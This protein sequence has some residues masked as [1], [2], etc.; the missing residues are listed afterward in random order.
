MKSEVMIFLLCCGQAVRLFI[1]IEGTVSGFLHFREPVLPVPGIEELS[2]APGNEK[3]DRIL[4]GFSVPEEI[5]ILHG[6]HNVFFIPQRVAFLLFERRNN[7][8]ADISRIEGISCRI[9]TEEIHRRLRF[10]QNRCGRCGGTGQQIGRKA[11]RDGE[12]EK[13]GRYGGNDGK[14]LS[15]IFLPP[16][17]KRPDG[18]ENDRIEEPPVAVFQEEGTCCQGSG[19]E[20]KGDSQCN[21]RAF[22]PFPDFRDSQS[23]K[24]NRRNDSD[25]SIGHIFCGHQG[26]EQDRTPEP[27]HEETV[28]IRF[29]FPAGYHFADRGTRPGEKRCRHQEKVVVEMIVFGMLGGGRPEDIVKA[30]ELTDEVFSVNQVHAD[31][32]G[33]TEKKENQDAL[34]G[35]KPQDQSGLFHGKTPENKQDARQDKSHRSLGEAG[36][37]GSAVGNHQVLFAVFR[38]PDVGGEKS[39]DGEEK[40]HAVCD[41]CMGNDPEFQR[42]REDDAGPG[43]NNIVLRKAEQIVSQQGCRKSPADGSGQPGGQVGEA[44]EAVGD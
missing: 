43:G 21:R 10:R 35:E 42:Q 27:D 38:D 1:L 4:C 5:R 22:F 23:G 13:C 33:Q 25:V 15:R 30:Q 2:V 7:P 18:V 34:P 8:R 36:Q 41:D 29:R 40:K 16:E 19:K 17:K 39:G 3:E 26:V 9:G 32:P 44:E 31:V 6:G 20:H 11:F 12:E 24:N 28:K 37:C 14:T